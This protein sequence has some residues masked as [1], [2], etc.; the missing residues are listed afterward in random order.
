MSYN[1]SSQKSGA[2]IND[3]D[4]FDLDR[5]LRDIAAI[6]NIADLKKDKV[7]K[8]RLMLIADELSQV[9]RNILD[10]NDTE[11]EIQLVRSVK[12]VL[13]EVTEWGMDDSVDLRGST[14]ARLPDETYVLDVAGTSVDG[15]GLTFMA[16]PAL[17]EIDSDEAS[18][19]E[20]KDLRGG[21]DEEDGGDSYSFDGNSP[22]ATEG[23]RP[24]SGD[25]SV[26]RAASSRAA[27]RQRQQDQRQQMIA[28]MGGVNIRDDSNNV[29]ADEARSQSSECSGDN[30]SS[31]KDESD[32]IL[33]YIETNNS[34]VF[35]EGEGGDEENVDAYNEGIPEWM[36]VSSTDASD[37]D[38]DDDDDKK[39]RSRT[40]VQ[41][42]NT[43]EF[44]STEYTTKHYI[45]LRNV[46]TSVDSEIGNGRDR[47]RQ[48][49]SRRIRLADKLE[50]EV[51]DNPD[52]YKT[53]EQIDELIK[54]Q[55]RLLQEFGY[56]MKRHLY[57]IN[58]GNLFSRLRKVL[59][60]LH[61]APKPCQA[62]GVFDYCH[63]MQCCISTDQ[64][65]IPYFLL[66]EQ[67]GHEMTEW[68]FGGMRDDIN[69]TEKMGIN[70]MIC[71]LLEKKEKKADMIE[72][73]E[74]YAQML[75]LVSVE[76]LIAISYTNFRISIIIQRLCHPNS[77][78]KIQVCSSYVAEF[79]FGYGTGIDKYLV[80]IKSDYG[81]TITF[82]VHPQHKLMGLWKNERLFPPDLKEIMS[83]ILC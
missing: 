19:V 13:D 17:P 30:E 7:E 8:I 21:G 82:C 55:N 53:T 52:N 45:P 20:A 5:L 61:Y 25:S 18:D 22:G 63:W 40:T 69:V 11:K 83:E 10:E 23:R 74:K 76:E 81:Y 71:F 66:N 80:V 26:S 24:S 1:P 51:K 57:D 72:Q 15:G 65:K 34:V 4:G 16:L 6:R 47:V 68:S 31:K 46:T 38:D 27:S 77:N 42:D 62:A 14:S 73:Y 29:M 44:A 32:E 33:E 49:T 75:D 54:D 39:Q 64:T 50:K 12:A 36:A 37:N 59:E 28:D 3:V 48:L 60:Y 56:E 67:D 2:T 58:F 9:L 41:I 35:A 78:C 70:D 79:L 43:T